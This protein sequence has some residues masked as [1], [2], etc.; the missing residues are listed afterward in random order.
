M[1]I[2]DGSAMADRAAMHVELKR[3]LDL[4]DYYGA[5]LDA[6]ND[7]L[8]ERRERELIVIERAGAFLEGCG[9]YGLRLLS[10]FGEH[11]LQVL[12]D[13]EWLLTS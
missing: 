7:C 5:N 12:L 9:D 13:C 6:L 8:G 4:P 1:I 2:L 11:G 10:L 3:K